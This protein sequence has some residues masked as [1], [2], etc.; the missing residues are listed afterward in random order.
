MMTVTEMKKA[1]L[2]KLNDDNAK[3]TAVKQDG[4]VCEAHGW[5]A[6]GKRTVKYTFVTVKPNGDYGRFSVK[7]AIERFGK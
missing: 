7:K 2:E 3:S 6:K 4:V 5:G 1:S